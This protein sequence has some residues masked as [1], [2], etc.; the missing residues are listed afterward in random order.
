MAA[1]LKNKKVMHET[2]GHGQIIDEEKRE[3]REPLIK[4]RFDEDN[5]D[6]RTFYKKDLKSKE[7]TITLES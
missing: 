5:R 2:F 6:Y 1:T 4:V 7:K 3:G